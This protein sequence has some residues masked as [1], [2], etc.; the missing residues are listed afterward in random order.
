LRQRILDP[1]GQVK[2]ET[3]IWSL[4]C[5][6]FGFDTGVFAADPRD[7]LRE[8]LPHGEDEL[9]DKLEL[10]PVNPSGPGDV[11]WTD[12][13]FSTP[14]GKIEFSSREAQR[15]WGV[16]PVPDYAALEEGPEAADCG[17]FPLQLL[18]CKTRERIHSQF[19]NLDWIREV[20]RPRRLDIHPEDARARG[21]SDEDAAD[22]WNDRG[23]TR[24]RVH[25]DHGILPGVVHAIE[26]RCDPDDP[27]MNRLIGDSATDMNHGATFYECL[28]EVKKA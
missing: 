28:V 17:R 7:T 20:E 4:L 11:V 14:S 26:G 24:V 12:G 3:E 2:T 9:L 1:P 5:E 25:L 19:G 23:S 6:R 21:L 27:E 10:G 16:D 22:V 15:L 13:K 8:M 18:T